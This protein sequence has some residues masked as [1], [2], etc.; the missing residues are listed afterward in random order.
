[1]TDY[2]LYKDKPLSKESLIDDLQK[3]RN[4]KLAIDNLQD[5][6][7]DLEANKMARDKLLNKES[8][9]MKKTKRNKSTP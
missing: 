9:T 8:I 6:Q 7:T 2:Y 3:Y 1:M 5:I 4:L